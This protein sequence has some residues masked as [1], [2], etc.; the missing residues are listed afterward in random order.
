MTSNP[1]QTL[2]D[3]RVATGFLANMWESRSQ[4]GTPVWRAV[5]P[6]VNTTALVGIGHLIVNGW[7]VTVSPNRDGGGLLITMKSSTTQ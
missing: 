7:L 6:Y 3:L 4:D 2:R 1:K 5:A